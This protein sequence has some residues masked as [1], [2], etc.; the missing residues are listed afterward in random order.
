MC[1]MRAEDLSLK[2]GSKLIVKDLNW[3]IKTGENWVLYGLNGCGKTT[4]LSILAGYKSANFG[5]NYIMGQEVTEDNFLALRQDIGFVSSSFFDQ[6]LSNE[7]ILDIVTAGKYGTLGFQEEEPSDG[8]VRAAKALLREF[9]LGKR[10]RYPFNTLSKG[11]QQRVLIARALM[12]NPK[13]LILDEPCSGLDLIA[14]EQ[15][16]LRIA[17]MA[18][19]KGITMVYVTHHTEE[20]LP[21]FNKAA[22][23][24]DGVIHS[25][26]DL[27]D[28]FCD[29]NL[30]DFFDKK[31]RVL[32]TEQH[33]FINLDFEEE[34][35]SKC[36]FD[37]GYKGAVQNG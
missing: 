11:Q 25:Q 19:E 1:I 36:K 10:D 33:F 29:D 26:G 9:G 17:Q 31:A 24:R 37:V 7:I 18:E 30:T 14:R 3:E 27:Q 34:Y 12:A 2:S 5:K 6:Y 4:L 15:F 16:L 28:V 22:L 8:D 32:W 35:Q 21:F 20:I 13:V 23:M